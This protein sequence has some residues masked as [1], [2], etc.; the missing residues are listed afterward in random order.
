LSGTIGDAMPNPLSLDCM[1]A[2]GR[3][4]GIA[5]RLLAKII[6][7]GCDPACFASIAGKRGHHRPAFRGTA[8]DP[9]PT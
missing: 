5:S 8:H 4:T 3:A 1:R 9:K 6:F 2:T 7:V